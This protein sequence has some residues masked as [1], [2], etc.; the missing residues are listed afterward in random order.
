M[1]KFRNTLVAGVTA[2]ALAL[3]AAPAMAQEAPGSSISTGSSGLGNALGADD[4]QEAMFGFD[5]T[6]S[7]DVDGI[8]KIMYGATVFSGV[9]I[10]GGIVY[11]VY[12]AIQ[13]AAASVG[14]ELPQL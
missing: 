10:I 1:R 3:T 9:V 6:G 5:K 7:S 8:D 14:I 11:A 12:P 2:G 4:D 13:D